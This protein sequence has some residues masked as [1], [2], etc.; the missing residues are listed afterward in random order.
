[1][2]WQSLTLY[3]NFYLSFPSWIKNPRSHNRQVSAGPRHRV[4]WGFLKESWEN[5]DLWRQK[6]WLS[7]GGKK[8][9]L[10][11]GSLCVHKMC[12]LLCFIISFFFFFLNH[13]LQWLCEKKVKKSRRLQRFYQKNPSC[14]TIGLVSAKSKAKMLVLQTSY[15]IL[16]TLSI[17]GIFQLWLWIRF[18]NNSI[19]NYFYFL[20]K[21]NL[22]WC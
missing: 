2:H 14:F 6:V 21:D 12:I 11:Y 22:E 15:V 8:N 16:L 19:N 18:L 7:W 10:N 17:L 13:L 20:R 4:R 1:M 3:F 5:S 9:L